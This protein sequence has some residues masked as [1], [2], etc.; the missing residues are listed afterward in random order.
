MKQWN[1]FNVITSQFAYVKIILDVEI[2]AILLMCSLLDCWE[3]LIVAMS[4]LT[5]IWTLKFDD[6][7]SFLMKEELPHKSI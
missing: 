7:S 1:E 3:N 5:P 4:T 2:R 6:I